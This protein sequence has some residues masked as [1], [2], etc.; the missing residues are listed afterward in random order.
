E[1]HQPNPQT[2]K[3]KKQDQEKNNNQTK[4]INKNYLINSKTPNQPAHQP[5]KHPPPN[6]HSG[7]TATPHL[8]SDNQSTRKS[9]NHRTKR[10]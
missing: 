1:K 9:Y 7:A 5:K 3:N 10:V 6:T 2:S 8:A 4:T